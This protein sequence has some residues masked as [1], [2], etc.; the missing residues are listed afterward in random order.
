MT[1]RAKNILVP[2]DF[3]EGANLAVSYA[4][5][6]A[7]KLG[8][9]VHLFHSDVV[10]VLPED[11]GIT[12]QLLS[13]MQELAEQT[14]RDIA[15]RYQRSGA[16][17][18]C[19]VKVGDPRDLVNPLA[20]ELPADLIVMGTHGRRGFRRALLGSVAEYT[21]RTAPCPVLVVPQPSTPGA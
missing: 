3:S 16:V 9:K 8:A 17:G 10:P 12:A 5:E 6:L 2:T 18:Q 21:V 19:I 7:S 11:T 20:L 4:F 1:F 14:L 13:D 15:T